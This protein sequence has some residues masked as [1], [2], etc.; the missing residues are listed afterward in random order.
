MLTF[1]S[2]NLLWSEGLYIFFGIVVIGLLG[3]I[4]FRPLLYITLIFFAFSLYFFRNPERVCVQ[5]LNDTATLICPADGTVV[6]I[7]YNRENGL[8]GYAQKISIYLSPIDVHVNWTPMAGVIEDVIYKPG[9]FAMAF[10]P[11]SSELNERNDIIIRNAQGDSILVRQI[12]G[13]IARR[14]CCWVN[15]NEQ[16][17]AGFKYGMIRFGSRVDI[18]MPHNVMLAVGVGQK[19][20][21]GQ[22][23]LGRWQ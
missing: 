19:V 20:L 12:A 11:K 1:F 13:T 5:A 17:N 23:V 15:K 16:V 10:L 9:T 4:F 8:E 7:Q 18:L 6:D 3:F 21:G 22:T 14:I 2:S